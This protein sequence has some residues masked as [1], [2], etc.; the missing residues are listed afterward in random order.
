MAD[1]LDMVQESEGEKDMSNE[2]SEDEE[3]MSDE[4][5]ED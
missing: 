4:N 2:N 1:A 5:S 3:E